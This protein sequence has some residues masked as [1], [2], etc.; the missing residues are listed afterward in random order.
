MAVN[1]FVNI[2]ESPKD[3]EVYNNISEATLLKK[4]LELNGI[5]CVSRVA[6]NRNYFFKGAIDGF[7]EGLKKYNYIPIL[8]ISCHGSDSGLQLSCEDEISWLE[9]NKNLCLLNELLNG[10]L[11]LCMS[12]CKGFSACQMAMPKKNNQNPFFALIGNTNS[13]TWAE[14]AIAYAT[15]YHLI[16]KGHTINNAVEIMRKSSDNND[17]KAITSLEAQKKYIDYLKQIKPE[18]LL[19]Q[20][21]QHAQSLNMCKK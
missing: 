7:I 8:H 3:E 1:F 19:N 20:L 12:S 18:G 13:P 16:I 5:K 2:I 14:T 21:M 9:V 10:S 4:V 11:L 6:I 17:W 15:F